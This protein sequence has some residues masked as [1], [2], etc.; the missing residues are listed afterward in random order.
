[1]G[2]QNRISSDFTIDQLNLQ[3]NR[4]NVYTINVIRQ[5]IDNSKHLIAFVEGRS[6]KRYIEHAIT[7]LDKGLLNSIEVI[8]AGG[9]SNV[10]HWLRLERAKAINKE[11]PK[12]FPIRLG[13]IDPDTNIKGVDVPDED[14]GIFL[15]HFKKDKNNCIEKGIESIFPGAVVDQIIQNDDSGKIME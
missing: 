11:V 4:Y 5:A 12:L 3:L 8:S 1:M 2:L 9:D 7:K 13:V 6:D 14:M 15:Y 10:Q